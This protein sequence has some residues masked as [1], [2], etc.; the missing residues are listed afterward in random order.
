MTTSYQPRN[1]TNDQKA[2]LKTLVQDGINVN[3]E[4][5]DLKAGLADTVK[6]L[7][8]ELDIPGSVLNKVIKV[9]MKNS[10]DNEAA[11]LDL[12]DDILTSIGRK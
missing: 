3:Q 2:K 8:Q 1:F 4:C 9:A 11:D 12:L 6:A 10:F 7:S 5:T